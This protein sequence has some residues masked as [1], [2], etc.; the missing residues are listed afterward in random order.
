MNLAIDIQIDGKGQL[1]RLQSHQA[2][3]LS[4]KYCLVLPT[5]LVIGLKVKK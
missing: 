2:T 1:P 5:D 3:S 4:A